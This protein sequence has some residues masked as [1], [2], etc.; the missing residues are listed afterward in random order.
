MATQ[1]LL[2]KLGFSM[3]EGM[4]AEWL[5]ADGA[6]VA[7]GDPLYVIE[8]DKSSQEVEAPASG[9]LRTIAAVGETYPVGSVLGEIG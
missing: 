4:L 9:T 8:S 5:V 3:E 6:T 7:E 2:P 1:I